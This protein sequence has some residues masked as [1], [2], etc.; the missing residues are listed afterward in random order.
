MQ[1]GPI[2]KAAREAAHMTQEQLGEKVGVS[3]V[4]IMRYEKGQRKPS[5]EQLAAL[6][7]ALNVDLVDW[8]VEVATQLYDPDGLFTLDREIR[9][10][11][12][13]KHGD[14]YSI[15]IFSPPA[16][17]VSAENV[18]D[19]FFDNLSRLNDDGMKRAI[20]YVCDLA[21]NPAYQRSIPILADDQPTANAPE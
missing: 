3:G 2:I 16:D 9:K 12:N 15:V 21:G 1:F 18:R 13:L 17:G 11:Y 7:V 4:T 8:M 19:H 20:A 5:F 14:T 6:A 10:H